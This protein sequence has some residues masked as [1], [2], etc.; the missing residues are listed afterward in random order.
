MAKQ[1]S[2]RVLVTLECC[3]CRQKVAKRTLGVSRYLSSKNKRNTPKKL[4]LGKYCKYCNKHTIHK[5]IK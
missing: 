1:K 3:E 2:P 4:E 5:E